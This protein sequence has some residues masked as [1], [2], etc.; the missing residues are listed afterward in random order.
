MKLRIV[1]IWIKLHW[2][3][4][5]AIL[6]VLFAIQWWQARYTWS[7]HNPMYGWPVSFNN[8]WNAT[9]RGGWHPW[10]LAL[11]VAVWLILLASVGYT[12]ERFW[13][14][15][16]RFQFSLGSLFGLQVIVAL[17]CALG[18]TEGYLRAHPNNGSIYPKYATWDGAFS[19]PLDAIFDSLFPKHACR[20]LGGVTVGLDIGLFTDP[21]VRWRLP[22]IAIIFAIGCV[23]Y[24][25][26][27]LISRAVWRQ[28]A[29]TSSR[30]PSDKVPTIARIIQWT[31]VVLD[32]FLLLQTSFPPVIY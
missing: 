30:L 32:V 31:L 7:I 13:R 11:D 28:A 3:T 9:G 15:T 6:T 27:S 20:D 25:T 29:A 5:I 19:E 22:R 14:K 12:L 4:R 8:V 17:L 1:Q 23:M 18:Y 24:T 2:A 10:L 21:L 16:N 26:G